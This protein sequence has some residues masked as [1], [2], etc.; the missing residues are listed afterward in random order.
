MIQ[1]NQIYNSKDIFDI[2]FYYNF[3]FDKIID[4]NSFKLLDIENFIIHDFI[5]FYNYIN[6]Q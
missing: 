4:I 5:E 2:Y 3:E 6:F 1:R